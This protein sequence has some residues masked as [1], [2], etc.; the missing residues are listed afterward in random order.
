MHVSPSML[1]P[2]LPPTTTII[3]IGANALE[4][5]IGANHP[6]TADAMEITIQGICG[7][8]PQWIA[9]RTATMVMVIVATDTSPILLTREAEQIIG[10]SII[11]PATLPITVI[12]CTN[13]PHRPGAIPPV[14][15]RNM[16]VQ[17][18]LVINLSRPVREK[19]AEPSI[20]ILRI[21]EIF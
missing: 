14:E 16:K 12:S 15:D 2:A 8:M 20:G 13:V 4:R 18:R 21:L 19:R 7:V 1:A 5:R 17:P 11:T 10:C 9:N 3:N 6:L